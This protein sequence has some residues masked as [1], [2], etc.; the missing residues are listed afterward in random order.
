MRKNFVLTEE[1]VAKMNDLIAKTDVIDADG[2]TYQ[3]DEASEELVI[4]YGNHTQFR[5]NDGAEVRIIVLDGQEEF[6]EYDFVLWDF[7]R[8]F[9]EDFCEIVFSNEE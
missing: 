7:M 2:F 9:A 6:D 5:Y 8:S 4:D 3:M 1:M